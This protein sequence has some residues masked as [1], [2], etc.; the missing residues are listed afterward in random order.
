MTSI[1][2][3]CGISGPAQNSKC[4]PSEVEN[5]QRHEFIPA[6]VQVGFNLEEKTAEITS[7]RDAIVGNLVLESDE[8]LEVVNATF[9]VEANAKVIFQRDFFA[10]FFNYFMNVVLPTAPGMICRG[11]PGVGKSFMAMYFLYKLL[12]EEYI[13]VYENVMTETVYVIPPTGKCRVFRGR[14]TVDVVSEF[15]G[16]KTVHLFDACAGS[17]SREP[18]VNDSKVIIFTSPNYNSYKQIQ[19]LGA[20]T[21][22]VPSYSREEMDK[23]R[24]FFPRT[25]D[26]TYERNLEMFGSGSIRLVLGVTASTAEQLVSEAIANTTVSNML[27]IVQRM[28]V[29]VVS[30]VKGPCSLFSTSLAKEADKNDIV[31]YYAQNVAWNISSDHIMHQLVSIRRDDAELFAARAAAVFQS[32]PGSEPTAGRYFE[33]V[34]PGFIA[35]GG[36]FNVRKLDGTAQEFKEKWSQLTLVD[37]REFIEL[38]DALERFNDPRKMYSYVRKM[39]G[40][41]AYSPPNKFLQ[42]TLRP[43]Y[44]ILLKSMVT[45]AKQLGKNDKLRLYFVVPSEQYEG[46][47]GAQSFAG[48]K[49]Q[50]N[51]EKLRAMNN[52]EIMKT[53]GVSKDDFKMVDDK[54]EQYVMRLDFRNPVQ[55]QRQPYKFSSRSFSTL[56]NN[57]VRGP[58][59]SCLKTLRGLLKFVK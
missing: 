18:I 53:I 4:Y 24:P 48:K 15:Q 19:R 34:A 22:T 30:G 10:L 23:R 27:D 58:V 11:P 12:L 20:I 55:K 59:Q 21:L 37:V 54:L 56:S 14:A 44:P 41:D 46:W 8:Y 5:N 51:A 1:C 43:S 42:C 31:S 33:S 52:E 36:K 39:E 50:Q 38:S 7:L 57:A 49:V 3:Y 9:P 40:F 2:K 26:K 35:R 45:I 32:I 28:D 6:P 17:N 29:N 16:K 13:V 25:D 47:L